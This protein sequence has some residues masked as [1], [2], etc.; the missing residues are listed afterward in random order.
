[1]NKIKSF[2]VAVFATTAIAFS[3]VPVLA[4]SYVID[5]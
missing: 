2:A 5:A 3:A 1:M 4:S